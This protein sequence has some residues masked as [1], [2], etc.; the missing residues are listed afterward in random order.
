MNASLLKL[1]NI[2]K[3]SAFRL[4]NVAGRAV[5]RHAET[6]TTGQAKVSW[7]PNQDLTVEVTAEGDVL[8]PWCGI[9]DQPGTLEVT[10]ESRHLDG[11]SLTFGQLC[12]TRTAA[13]SPIGAGR[14]RSIHFAQPVENVLM[15]ARGADSPTHFRY[16]VPN[17]PFDGTDQLGRYRNRGML[18]AFTF[19]HA[20]Q[21][22]AFRQVADRDPVGQHLREGRF[23]AAI[24]CVLEAK[25]VTDISR[26]EETVRAVSTIMEAYEGSRIRPLVRAGYNPAGRLVQL[27]FYRAGT[28]RFQRCQALAANRMNVITWKELIEGMLPGFLDRGIYFFALSQAPPAFAIITAR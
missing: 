10:L 15:S 28:I 14:S 9:G 4:R 23:P 20:G 24:T 13:Q 2:P 25:D 6:E 17:F 26:L 16:W 3:A 5:L 22:F 1:G 7:L 18:D 11:W 21:S 8:A 19:D 27:L 12:V